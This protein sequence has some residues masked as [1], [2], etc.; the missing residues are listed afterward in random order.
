[1]VEVLAVKVVVVEVD[2][3]DSC[4][5]VEFV[6]VG[7]LVFRVCHGG[8]FACHLACAPCVDES[9]LKGF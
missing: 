8:R 2:V 3:L 1:M 5:C 6:C 9:P 4:D 7:D